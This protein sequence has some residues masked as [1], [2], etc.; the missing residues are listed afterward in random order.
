ML[1]SKENIPIKEI[2][3]PNYNQYSKELTDKFGISYPAKTIPFYS[4][5]NLSEIP[6]ALNK[7][8]KG[9]GWD[10]QSDVRYIHAN[11][12]P[13]VSVVV[14][15]YNQGAYIEETIRSILLQNYPNVE[16]I[17]VDGGS[18]DDTI[19]ILEHYRNFISV[20]ISE[21]DRGQSH[22]INKGFSLASGDLFFWI[23]SDDFANA[24]AFNRLVEIFQ[25]DRSL[26]IVYGDGLALN[27]STGVT[28]YEPGPFVHNRYL[29]FAAIILSHSIMWRREVHCPI[30]EDLNCPM[31]AELWLRLFPRR[32]TVHCNFAVSTA[33]THAEQKTTNS[34]KWASKWKEDYEKY[35]WP[36]YPSISQFD[37]KLRCYEYRLVQKLYN[38]FIRKNS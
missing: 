38:I 24:N 1:A 33:R 29:R 23:N 8:K 12:V 11:E 14:P 13:K 22:A 21:K 2:P 6:S 32:K 35:I 36:S 17:I 19:E 16:L 26:D 20:S 25:K 9:W 34:E 31:D 18:S 10:E 28:R 3:L 37:W 15:S 4:L 7:S 30:W 27:E 5:G